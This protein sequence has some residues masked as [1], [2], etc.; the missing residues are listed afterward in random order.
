MTPTKLPPSAKDR[1][2][3]SVT[4]LG[5]VALTRRARNPLACSRCNNNEH[6]NCT[7]IRRRIYERGT[8]PC[9]CGVCKVRKEAPCVPY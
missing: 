9:E 3:A 7:G 8:A 1:I 4:D 2:C 6:A 5:H